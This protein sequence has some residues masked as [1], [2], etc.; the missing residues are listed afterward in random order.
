[1][2]EEM[3]K[4]KRRKILIFGGTTEGRII[5]ERLHKSSKYNITVCTATSYGGELLPE[6]DEWLRIKSERLNQEE[7]LELLKGESVGEGGGYELVVDATHPY[8]TMVS[9]NIKNSCKQMLT[10]R[11][12]VLR[13]ASQIEIVGDSSKQNPRAIWF[14]NVEK[15][16]DFLDNVTGNIFST[17][18][19]KELGR[20]CKLKN[21][22]QRVYA[23]ILPIENMVAEVKRMGFTDDHLICKQGPFSKEENLE[24]I[25]KCCAAYLVTKESG[26][27]GGFEE[28]VLACREC[29]VTLLI[30]GRPEQPEENALGL[31][32]ALEW[33]DKW[34]RQEI[35]QTDNLK[36]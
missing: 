32:E 18:G 3:S 29:E 4:S 30:I 25:K 9:E 2:R 35:E 11:I 24:H 15:C 20:F 10:K 22:E 12:R 1:M 16:V 13:E 23:R 36:K 33:I 19:S 7:M 21:F 31:D 5:T 6:E 14:E 26:I 28:K 34:N 8:A 17:I 27:A